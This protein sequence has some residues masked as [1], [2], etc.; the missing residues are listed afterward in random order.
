MLFANMLIYGEIEWNI[1][2][3]CADTAQ[4]LGTNSS[5]GLLAL[6]IGHQTAFD[7]LQGETYCKAERK[8][9]TVFACFLLVRLA[10]YK[11]E[12][13][14]LLFCQDCAIRKLISGHRIGIGPGIVFFGRELLWPFAAEANYVVLASAYAIVVIASALMIYPYFQDLYNVNEALKVANRSDYFAEKR[15]SLLMTRLA[16]LLYALMVMLFFSESVTN[17]VADYLT[18]FGY[19]FS[20]PYVNYPLFIFVLHSF[21]LRTHFK[22]RRIYVVKDANRLLVV[23]IASCLNGA[24][25]IYNTTV[26]VD[27][28]NAL[29]AG[30]KTR[31]SEHTDMI[32]NYGQPIVVNTYSDI[33]PWLRQKFA[34]IT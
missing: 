13:L 5:A 28:P 9:L 14:F 34:K 19:R 8:A 12:K 4:L 24:T 33:E 20:F 18:I 22:H 27:P 30:A 15:C 7:L 32:A 1:K 31:W 2:R 3:S 10:S 6:S 23:E 11:F 25:C 26:D 17:R 16:M 21:I 29:V